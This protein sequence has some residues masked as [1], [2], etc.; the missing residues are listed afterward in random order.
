MYRPSPYL[1][2]VPR[3]VDHQEVQYYVILVDVHIGL[4][5][6]RVREAS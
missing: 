3:L 2:G 4:G 5:I 1:Q 6:H